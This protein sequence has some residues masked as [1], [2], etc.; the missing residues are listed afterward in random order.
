[1]TDWIA[2][3]GNLTS[4]PERKTV[5][6]GAT[7]VTFGLASTER[8]LDNGAWVD[9]NTNFYNVSVF[10]RLGEHAFAS[11][12]KGQRVIVQGKLTLRRW[13]ANG[14]KGT[15]ID[16]EASSIGPDLL[17]GVATFVKDAGTGSAASQTPPED[18]WAPDG[19]VDTKT[20]EV[21]STSVGAEER[22]PALVGA[23]DWGAPP[24]EEA[25]PF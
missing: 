9:G 24:T 4:P 16:L 10:R 3:T 11:L 17:F 18:E 2:V 25:A 6:G 21:R 8:R 12:E 13:E 7:L 22:T 14:R 23:G 19:S 20:G 15:S 1:M 5:T